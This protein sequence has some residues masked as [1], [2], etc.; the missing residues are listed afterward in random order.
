MGR[1][2]ALLFGIL[3]GAVVLASTFI[4]AVACLYLIKASDR[5]IEEGDTVTVLS[6]SVGYALGATV[7][8]YV[9]SLIHMSFWTFL[10]AKDLD[11]VGDLAVYL[12]YPAVWF[13]IELALSFFWRRRGRAMFGNSAQVARFSISLG[14]AAIYVAGTF[15][16]I[17]LSPLAEL[18]APSVSA[19]DY[20]QSLGL[21]LQTIVSMLTNVEFALSKLLGMFSTGGN[22][23]ELAPAFGVLFTVTA[24][25]TGASV[26]F[27]LVAQVFPGRPAS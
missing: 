17:A 19:A 5:F 25:L 4:A 26:L 15:G 7:L 16:S 14:L 1:E 23:F 22:F 2:A 11:V 13:G 27:H 21:G 12:F 8:L 24:L 10:A 20:A 3:L 6:H 18:G 9:C